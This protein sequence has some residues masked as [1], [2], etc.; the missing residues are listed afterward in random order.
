MPEHA[1][2]SPGDPTS[3]VLTP[4]ARPVPDYELVKQIGQGGY[5]E[6]WKAQAPGGFA[7]ALK[8]IRLGNN[9]S[10]LELRSLELMKDIRHPNLLSIFGAWRREPFLIVAMELADCSLLDRLQEASEQGLPGIPLAEVLEYMREAAKGIDHLNALGIQHRDIKPHNLLLIGHSVK[11]A[12]FGLAKLLEHSITSNTGA[13]TLAYAAPEFLRGRTSSQSDQYALAVSYCQLR[14]CRLP[15]AGNPMQVIAGHATL[16]PNLGMLPPAERPVVARALAKTPAR[17]WRS[18]GAFVEALAAAVSA[19]GLTVLPPRV[20]LPRPMTRAASPSA[21][22]ARTESLPRAVPPVTSATELI[23]QPRLVHHR[24]LRGQQVFYGF[25][26]LVA[27]V[28]FIVTLAVHASS[29]SP[30]VHPQDKAPELDQ[31]VAAIPLWLPFAA[32]AVPAACLAHAALAAAGRRHRRAGLLVEPPA[33]A[34]L[35]LVAIALY[36][37]GNLAFTVYLLASQPVRDDL[38][39]SMDPA[40]LRDGKWTLRTLTAVGM[41]FFAALALLLFQVLHAERTADP[42]RRG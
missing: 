36:A 29:L 15:F 12:D 18:C 20:A 38:V 2:P 10:A 26:L 17:R 22:L 42:R 16:R 28:A 6:V 1:P 7:V 37:F 41:A 24:S 21:S 35:A 27:V 34:K 14:G 39:N 5:G 9:A 30:P 32:A 11:V 25:G 31:F 40:F 4:G 33:W 13:M 23:L 3:L 8:F 19:Q